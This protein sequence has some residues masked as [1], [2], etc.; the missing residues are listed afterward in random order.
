MLL[1]MKLNVVD[2]TRSGEAHRRRLVVFETS[3][4]TQTVKVKSF[5]SELHSIFYHVRMRIYTPSVCSRVCHTERERVS[6][7]CGT[8]SAARVRCAIWFLFGVRVWL[9]VEF[10]RA[11]IQ[12][13]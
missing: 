8:K 10:R 4:N 2:N 1:T 3:A 13:G 12:C 9:C 5:K 6:R 7:V 11:F